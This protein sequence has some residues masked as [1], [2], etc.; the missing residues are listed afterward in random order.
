MVANYQTKQVI[1]QKQNAANFYGPNFNENLSTPKK[2]RG[3]D[4]VPQDETDIRTWRPTSIIDS[5]AIGAH[6]VRHLQPAGSPSVQL[7]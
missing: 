4:G 5:L 7:V 2:Q 6:S 3:P 1:L